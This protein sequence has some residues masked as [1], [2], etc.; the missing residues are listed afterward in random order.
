MVEILRYSAFDVDGEGGNPAGVVLRSAGL[1]ESELL[2]IAADVAYSETAFVDGDRIRFFS[3]LAEVAFCGHATIAT[4]VALAERQGV[5]RRSF[6]SAVGEIAVRTEHDDG[7]IAATLVSAV[8]S[9]RPV[10]D[11]DLDE[12]LAALGWQAD[13]LDAALPPRIA[14]AGNDHLVLAAATRARLAVL[15]Y[16]FDRL[17]ALMADRG[18]TTLQLVWREG[19]ASFLSRNPFPPGGVVEDPATG[20]AAAAF[21][22]YLRE[23]GLVAPAAR[24]TI[25][26]GVDLG[27]PSRLLV[28]VPEYGGIEVT[29]TAVALAA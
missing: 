15:D 1:G 7:R 12:S 20:A 5:G 22:G 9:V 28:R 8:P 4:A 13:E 29:G 25:R 26:Q 21:G 16:D 14:N 11:A 23:L 17:Q 18:W 2:R 6:S 27:R 3:A 19:P 24:L 10:P